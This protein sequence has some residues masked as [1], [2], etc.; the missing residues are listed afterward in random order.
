MISVIRTTLVVAAVVA[1]SA[2]GDDGGGGDGA[3]VASLDDPSATT[4]DGSTPTTT[5]TDIEDALVAYTECMREHGVDVP[6]PQFGEDGS[7]QMRIKG[8]GLDDSKVQ[9]ADEACR[10][11]MPAIGESK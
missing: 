2:C 10:K 5:P 8:K 3:E 11:T 9:A 6:D 4:I 7:V 1:V